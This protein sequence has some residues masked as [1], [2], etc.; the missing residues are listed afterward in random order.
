[1]CTITI[2]A[3]VWDALTDEQRAGLRNVSA[4]VGPILGHPARV[5]VG[6]VEWCHFVDDR[7]DAEQIAAVEALLE[8]PETIPPAAV[9][10]IETE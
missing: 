1:M 10:P 9:D 4:S 2:P 3:A 7:I 6:E 8:N 5:L